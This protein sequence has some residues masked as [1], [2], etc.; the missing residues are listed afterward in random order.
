MHGEAVLGHGT[1]G[2]VVVV[3]SSVTDEICA[4]KRIRARSSGK[5][6]DTASARD[7]GESEV[8]DDDDP[9]L[10]QRRWQ[11]LHAVLYDHDVVGRA[12]KSFD[13]CAW[14]GNA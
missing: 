11:P 12:T 6:K 14:T 2:K 8:H 7:T 9:V 5:A 4:L 3:K 1:Y 10:L 13:A